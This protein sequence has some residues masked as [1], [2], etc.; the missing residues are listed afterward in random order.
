VAG[1]DGVHLSDSATSRDVL[2]ELMNRYEQPLSGYLAVLLSDRD[3]VRDC[4][5]ETFL[6][7]YEHLKRGKAVNGQWLYK[8]ARNKAIDHLRH[9]RRVRSATDTLDSLEWTAPGESERIAAVRRTLNQLSPDDREILYLFI[10]DKFETVE[11]GAMLG[12]RVGAVRVRL[13]RARE[14]FRAL[15]QKDRS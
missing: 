3:A 8:V 12:I 2:V 1:I 5:Q 14:R 4:A 13:F 9:L 15:Y 11:I 10:V 6:R 7:A